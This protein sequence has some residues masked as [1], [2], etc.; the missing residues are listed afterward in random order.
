MEGL[1]G[2]GD[3][4]PRYLPSNYSPVNLFVSILFWAGLLII[5]S[6]PKFYKKEFVW[7]FLIIST[8]IFGQIMTV[9]PPNGGRA[10]IMLPA[11]Y[12]IGSLAFDKISKLT[13]S[14]KVLLIIGATSIIF[15]LTDLLFYSF[16]M[17]WIRV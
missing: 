11:Y 10:L 6:K 7:I 1:D 12:I 9:N 5:F 14:N 17:T 8:V 13:K 15:S 2:G 16:W 3:E 4:N